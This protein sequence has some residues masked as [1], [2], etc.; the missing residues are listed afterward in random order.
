MGKT[1]EDLW[2]HNMVLS[3][4]DGKTNHI[5]DV[6]QV[7]LFVGSTLRPTL[8]MV[9]TSNTN[10]NLLLVREWIHGINMVPSTLH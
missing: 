9:I 1:D 10:Y 2:P 6:I 8:F 3:N 5:L 7:E 4:Y